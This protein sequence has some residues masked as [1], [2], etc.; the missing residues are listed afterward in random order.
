[1][2]VIPQSSTL[3]GQDTHS[4]PVAIAP[5]AFGLISIRI[6]DLSWIITPVSLGMETVGEKSSA[7]EPFCWSYNYEN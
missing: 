7:L 6:P 5:N 3:K 2:M 4:N 1:M